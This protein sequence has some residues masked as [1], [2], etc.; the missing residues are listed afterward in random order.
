[1]TKVAKNWY[2]I[3]VKPGAVHPHATWRREP[4]SENSEKTSF[5]RQQNAEMTMLE[6][7]MEDIGVECFVPMERKGLIHHRTKRQ[8]IRRFPLLPGWAFVAGVRDWMAVEAISH[9]MNFRTD[10]PPTRI[11]ESEIEKIRIA[12]AEINVAHTINMMRRSN[13]VR[14]SGYHHRLMNEL[15]PALQL[16]GA[17]KVEASTAWKA[18]HSGRQ[19]MQRVARMLAGGVDAKRLVA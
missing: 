6:A 18:E 12:E 13:G 9:V 7:A 4:I 1:M 5:N 14:W 3:R 16:V 19:T 17:Q 8:I 2:A 11:S 15:F 10:N